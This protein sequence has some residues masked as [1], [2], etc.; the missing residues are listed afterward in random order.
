MVRI[1]S[2]KETL[3]FLKAIE[4][5]EVTTKMLND[6]FN[7]LW[8]IWKPQQWLKNSWSYFPISGVFFIIS[9]LLGSFADYENPIFDY[10]IY[11]V[12]SIAIAF[13]ILATWQLIK[14]GRKLMG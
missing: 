13:L 6:F 4:A 8:A 11:T 10:S 9:G 1:F 7:Q 14:L 5:G 12:L 3:V 2:S